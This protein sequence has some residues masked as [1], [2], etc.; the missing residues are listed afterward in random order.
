MQMQMPMAL[1]SMAISLQTDDSWPIYPGACH[2]Q[3]QQ[4]RHLCL[5]RNEENFRSIWA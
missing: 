2:M 4:A 1:F 5:D 3:I